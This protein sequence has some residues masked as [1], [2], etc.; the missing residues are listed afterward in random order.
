MK[1][2]NGTGKLVRIAVFARG[3]KAEE[4]KAAGATVV[5]AEDLVQSIQD[6]KL[7][8]ERCIATPDMM[9]LVGRIARIMTQ[10][11]PASGRR[12]AAGDCR[13]R[14]GPRRGCRKP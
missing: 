7:D 14:G 12:G 4:A 10:L 13:A 9:P 5:G 11:M 2:P 6:G 8:F 1:L 3:D